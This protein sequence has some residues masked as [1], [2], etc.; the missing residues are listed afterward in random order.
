MEKETRPRKRSW[1]FRIALIVVAVIV[2]I[3][4]LALAALQTGSG[5]SG[6]AGLAEDLASSDTFTLRLG[7]IEG[8]V[9][10]DMRVSNV[11]IGDAE[12]IWLQL[13]DVALD[14]Q[15]L[16][17]LAGHV[18]VDD[19]SAKEIALLR[20][21]VSSGEEE[22][23]D[24]E[25][26]GLPGITVTVDKLTVD[27]L[28]LGEAIPGGPATFRIGGRFAAKN[29]T[30]GL[31]GAL[32]AQR[33][34]DPGG[35]LKAD[36]DYGFAGSTVALDAVLTDPE[37]GYVASLFER[38]DLPALD[39]SMQLSGTLDDIAGDLLLMAGNKRAF[40]GTAR[41][42]SAGNAQRITTKLDGNLAGL[43]PM[44]W[45]AL[46]G[47]TATIDLDAT[48][49]TDEAEA[50]A[51]TVSRGTVRL[52]ALTATLSGRLGVAGSSDDLRLNARLG[53]DDGT[54][55][56]LPV[57]G[58]PIRLNALQIDSRIRPA[59]GG[60]AWHVHTEGSGIATGDIA[61]G[62]AVVRL[63]G[64]AE[65]PHIL[66]ARRVPATLN[67]LIE[68]LSLGDPDI[69]AVVGGKI[70]LSA[71][72]V[73]DAA[74]RR[75]DV[76]ESAV[77]TSEL[78]L[79]YIGEVTDQAL[80]GRVTLSIP[81]L[82]RFAE[83]TGRP[84]AGR[85]QL[86]AD[87]AASYS[88]APVSLKFDGTIDNLAT[89]EAIVDGLLGK[90]TQLSGA[91]TRDD[92]G[93]LAI[94]TL[95]VR[96]SGLDLDATG[97][98]TPETADLGLTVAIKDLAAVDPAMAGRLNADATLKGPLAAP[99]LSLAGTG[100]NVRLQG[101]D[102]TDPRL[103][104]D[105]VLSPEAP[106]GTLSLTARLDSLPVE[107]HA[108]VATDESGVK[109]I[110]GL[111]LIAGHNRA[112]GALTVSPE[113]VPDGSIAIDAPDLSELSPLVLQK[114]GGAITGKIDFLGKQTP[115]RIDLALDAR[116]VEAPG[117]KLKT[118]RI[119]ATVT[120]PFGKL[121]AEGS[122]DL[123]DLG[124]GDTVISS[125]RATAKSDGPATDIN[126][127]AKL[128]DAQVATKARLTPTDDGLAIEIATLDGRYT[129]IKTRLVDPANIRLAGDTVQIDR[130]VLAVGSGRIALSGSVADR[131]DLDIR[132]DDFPLAL[133]NAFAP[134]TGAA[135]TLTASAKVTGPAS[136]PRA[137]WKVSARGATA[138][139][140]RAQGLPALTA[141]A[142]GQFAK[143]VVRLDAT[144]GGIS[145]M[146]LKARGTVPAAP[147]GRL[148][149][150]VDG[151]VPFSVATRTLADSGL[152][153]SGAAK[154]DLTVTGPL[155]SPA[156]NGT[157]TTSGARVTHIESGTTIENLSARLKLSGKQLS[158]ESVNGR[159]AKGGTLTAS[160]TIGVFD[161]AL[162]GDIRVK[163]DD[164]HYVDGN[165]VSAKVAADLKV[166]GS[167]A[168]GP[169]V[170]GKVTI[171]RADINIPEQV[172]GG[173][174]ALD[175]VHKNAPP[176]VQQQVREVLPRKDDKGDSDARLD[177]EISAPARIFVRGRGLD[178]E[179]GGSLKLRGPVGAPFVEG[180]FSMRRGRLNILSR[181][182][183]FERGIVRFG[184]DF[185]PLLDF[186][187][188]T[189]ASEVTIMISI[190]G[191]ASAPD[192]A[193]RSSP[194]LPQDEV[195]SRFLFDRGVDKLS[196][197]QI[198]QL[199]AS[200][201]TLTGAGGGPGVLDQVRHGLGVDRLEATTD[202]KGK[203][204]L[205]AGKY[206]ADD[207][208]VGVKQGTGKGSTKVTIDLDITENVK[209]RGEVGNDGES[210]AGIFFEKDY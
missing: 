173:I 77:R 146:S 105:A 199:A 155:G 13:E 177:L 78:V 193:F 113:N 65:T 73:V 190:N 140:L 200:I 182:V 21:P 60:L 84:L 95:A 123:A 210:K 174:A 32:T 122:A 24:E 207:V 35:A 116:N 53:R 147:T 27:K 57:G 109:R 2:A 103:K 23:T 162:P 189:K 166:S 130:T 160:G 197:F 159:L 49:G 12:G 194:Q 135:G 6:I 118:A 148:D 19:V 138:N 164:G 205:T 191:S 156:I 129:S 40:G 163:L 41:V 180:G 20:L 17:L 47:G 9:P 151:T 75:A 88:G 82:S 72:A 107:A 117:A 1:A 92:D 71:K 50:I 96:S 70:A 69:D 178:A 80:D 54:A 44:G 192:F 170:S 153:A 48:V 14:W 4:L 30:E 101:K 85:L 167:F 56:V 110:D 144:V 157:V 158:I 115:P 124:A 125:V 208:F 171:D 26:G 61:L 136:D 97:T 106:N 121:Q 42:V 15:V 29:L 3:P 46:L 209:T 34:D 142:S 98:V 94:D 131:L 165:L 51:L 87:T 76:S 132:I 176:A 62:D 86:A 143:G 133:A 28:V 186:Y 204:E 99:E 90:A 134:G 59:G 183:A 102:L 91:L 83:E 18:A 79:G 206:I 126:V 185:D 184:G 198:A 81:D 203:A 67:G 39:L 7:T 36:F 93:T 168:R 22:D 111:K 37:G 127:T 63:E 152:A 104:V 114:I 55:L 16:P 43:V 149:I 33:L 196:A 68:G 141:D 58:D 145:N 161:P 188:T 128:P 139:A 181:R 120:D 100:S 187:A 25:G 74:E 5:R 10:F 66:S 201:A 202:E 179:L 38:P 137:D 31:N 108:E 45:E 11:A 195:L 169:T 150:S 112:E 89:G 8:S 52:P 154:V 175:I 172:P 119:D 64:T